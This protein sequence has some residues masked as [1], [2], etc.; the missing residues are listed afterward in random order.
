MAGTKAAFDARAISEGEKGGDEVVGVQDRVDVNGVVVCRGLVGKVEYGGRPSGSDWGSESIED[1]RVRPHE[2]RR[3]T[4]CREGGG[5]EGS[6]RGRKWARGNVE[7]GR[8][9]GGESA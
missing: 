7:G 1:L 4:E 2:A 8:V 9:I 3:D 6:E 5:E